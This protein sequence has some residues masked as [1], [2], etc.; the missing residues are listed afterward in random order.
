M[1][2]KGCGCENCCTQSNIIYCGKNINCLDIKKGDEIHST[3]KK[4]GDAICQI[5]GDPSTGNYINI[6]EASEDQCPEGGYVIQAIDSVTGVV[7]NSVPV[8][9]IEDL[10]FFN[11]VSKTSGQVGLG[12]SLSENTVIEGDGKSFVLQNSNSI[13]FIAVQGN[14]T[15]YMNAGGAGGMDF[16]VVSTNGVTGIDVSIDTYVATKVAGGAFSGNS[17][18]AVKN[19]L[20]G[21]GRVGSTLPVRPLDVFTGGDPIRFRDLPSYDD[22]T[23]AGVAGLTTGDCYQTTGSGAAPLNVAGILMAKQ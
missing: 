13:T 2:K 21:I 7:L 9:D 11:G 3:I 15:F 5:I 23:S 8:C 17:I 19:G 20:V 14:N 6:I 22:D 12:G 10:T 1:C 18:L 16:I 4:L